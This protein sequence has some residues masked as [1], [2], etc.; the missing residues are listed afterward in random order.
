[1]NFSLISWNEFREA[2][3]QRQSSNLQLWLRRWKFTNEGV[4]LAD[5]RIAGTS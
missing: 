2:L 3:K 4:I 1:M 5:P